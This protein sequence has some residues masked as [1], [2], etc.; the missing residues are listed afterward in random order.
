MAVRNDEKRNEILKVAF[1]LFTDS[2]YG[3]VSLADIAAS[4]DINKS[5]LQ[6]YYPQRKN[7]IES[8]L[9][10]LLEKSYNYMLSAD[11]VDLFQEISDFNM[12]FFKTASKNKK[13]NRFIVVS[14]SD[15]ELLE[16]WI[17][18]ICR[19]LRDICGEDTFSYLQLRTAIS[20]SMTGSMYLYL[21][22]DELN[23]NYK[24][25]LENH[26]RSIVLMLGISSERR[27]EICATTR[28]RTDDFNTDRFIEFCNKNIDWINL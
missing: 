8:M 12:L 18:I 22:K 11:S 24:Y 6:H 16:L 10:E 2:D 26:F 15:H 27:D 3:K 4:A 17:D 25:I 9:K 14:V 5:L 13:L 7:I 23:L 19:W 28:I 21:H 20:F 1:N